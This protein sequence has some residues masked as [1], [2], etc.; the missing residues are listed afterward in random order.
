MSYNTPLNCDYSRCA[1]CIENLV[2][3]GTTILGKYVLK[4]YKIIKILVS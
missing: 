2:L 4:Q 1:T 3:D